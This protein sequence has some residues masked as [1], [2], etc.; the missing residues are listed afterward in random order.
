[1]A[2]SYFQKWREAYF[3]PSTPAPPTAPV[4]QQMTGGIPELTQPLV[5]AGQGVADRARETFQ[6][7]RLSQPGRMAAVQMRNGLSMAAPGFLGATPSL[8]SA[9]DKRTGLVP[10]P[11]KP[12]EAAPVDTS[13]A[14]YAERP[15]PSFG[16]GGG[17]MAVIPGGRRTQAWQVQEGKKFSDGTFA[18]IAAA[19]DAKERVLTHEA[20]A[21]QAAAEREAAF[22]DGYE[23]LLGQKQAN[24]AAAR[25]RRQKMMDDEFQKLTE[26][27]KAAA[28]DGGATV[29]GKAFGGLMATLGVALGAWGGSMDRTGR[30]AGAEALQQFTNNAIAEQRAKADREN[31]Y[32]ARMKD[33]FGD[34]QK[35]E[36]AT[37]MAFNEAMQARLAN[38]AATT[39]S[40]N[41]KAN[42]DRV[43]AQ[44]FAEKAQLKKE[45]DLLQQD[46][47]QRSD[48]NVPD[49]VIGL[50]VPAAKQADV[51]KVGEA[52]TREKIP[53]AEQN[54]AEVQKEI[55][56][57]GKQ[58][59]PIEGVTGTSP[60]GGWWES[61][62]PDFLLTPKG[63]ANRQM[64][65]NFASNYAHAMS[66]AGMS[67][68]ERE[69]YMHNILGA[70]TNEEMQRAIRMADD[71]L[72]AR[73]RTIKATYDPRAVAEFD[74][75]TGGGTTKFQQ[76]GVVP[77]MKPA[78]EK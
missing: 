64:V 8:G 52:L 15:A 44:T 32:Y 2:D 29:A 72:A 28:D 60:L 4:A 73:K 39:K 16:G 63:L 31:N 18:S 25:A 6:S 62:K 10:E 49:R 53:E 27:N 57:Y 24:E 74:K 14:T 23:A 22:A 48:A 61:K 42:I 71:A 33:M 21:G 20:K 11:P 77:T 66:G 67:D 59:K 50:G 58:D 17:G 9:V 46:T 68:A 40:E 41:A 56:A 3:G 69:R 76:R 5:Q 26:A 47:V 45:F 7:A 54:L 35:A 37:R 43:A 12:P 65:A 78:G 55:D 13:D 36:V 1:M 51:E 30:N 70:R 19:E 34:E 38:M 75:R